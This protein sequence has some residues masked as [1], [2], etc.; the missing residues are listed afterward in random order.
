[1]S[2][3][4]NII[5]AI[6]YASGKGLTE[7]EIVKYSESTIGKVRN[8]LKKL[9]E[10]YQIK[11]S[12]LTISKHQNK[13]KLTVR[14]KYSDYIKQLAS[15]TEFSGTILKTLAV[16]AYKSPVLQSD[17]INMRGQ[18]AYDHIK[19]LVKEKFIT[20]QEEGRS[21]ILKITD[22]FYNY[23]DV[24]GD[25]EIREIFETLRKQQQKEEIAVIKLSEEAEKKKQES[26]TE[27]G[28]LEV[29][30]IQPQRKEKTEE[31][32]KAEED[33]LKNIDAQ[34]AQV[35]EN[36]SKEELPK[37][38]SEKT[39]NDEQSKTTSNEEKPN[40]ETTNDVQNREEEPE[41][42]EQETEEERKNTSEPENEKSNTEESN[43]KENY[44]E[45][46]EEFADKTTSKEN[47]KDDEDFI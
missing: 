46:L 17:I 21:Y 39:E 2:E 11:D 14:A 42:K 3:L 23:F 29:V 38:T 34:L 24:E 28:N 40:E 33:F 5:E 12:S 25:E 43:D 47:A 1:M 13:W 4:K 7:D 31:D 44:L 32:K 45:E 30:D 27:M 22:K 9:Q 20:K 26:Q 35:S 36:V 6:L 41:H 37:V 8:R 10:E 16:I 19:R 18:G 15:E